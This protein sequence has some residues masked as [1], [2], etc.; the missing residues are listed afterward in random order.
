MNIQKWF[1]LGLTGLISCQSKGLSRVFSSTTIWKHQF[2]GTQSFLWSNFPFVHDYLKNHSFVWITV[3]KVISLLFNTLSRFA[4]VFLLRSKCL[5]ISWLQ[6]MSTVIL[7]S[8]KIKSVTFSTF[9]SSIYHEVMGRDGI[10]LCFLMLSFKPVSSFSSFTFI[11]RI[12]FSSSISVIRV[13]SSVYLRLLIFLLEILIL[14]CD[15]SSLTFH[16]IKL[17]KAV[18]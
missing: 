16:M 8:K 9:S 11:K 7:K 2:F 15:S 18:K 17:F 13:V 12:C 6:S 5:L 14:T 10:I 1:P 3:S 4:I